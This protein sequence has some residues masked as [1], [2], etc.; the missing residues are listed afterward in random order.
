MH[1]SYTRYLENKIREAFGFAGNVTMGRQKNRVQLRVIHVYEVLQL[2]ARLHTDMF[3]R[4]RVVGDE[5]ITGNNGVYVLGDGQCWK[6]GHGAFCCSES[7]GVCRSIHIRELPE[8]LLEDACP[9]LG[10]MMN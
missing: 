3:G 7:G 10:L 2:Y 6:E 1:F 4:I 9:Y 8:M 5:D